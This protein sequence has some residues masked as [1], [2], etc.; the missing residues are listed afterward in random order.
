MMD[1]APVLGRRFQRDLHMRNVMAAN[2]LGMLLLLLSCGGGK[3]PSA[4][5][6][7]WTAGLQNSTGAVA[8][9]FT[10][11]LT[12]NTGTSVAVSRFVLDPSDSCFAGQTVESA[13]LSST[14][15]LSGPFGMTI[16][17]QGSQ[18]NVLTIQGNLLNAQKISGTWTL[19]GASGCSGSGT[20]QMEPLPPV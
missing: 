8:F 20:V 4:I 5:N 13:T 9:G 11:Q 6:G 10:A 16:T 14:G 1:N 12:Q 2:L 7:Y 15:N 17:S 19:T 3:T 18:S